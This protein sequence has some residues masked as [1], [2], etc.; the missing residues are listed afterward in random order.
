MPVLLTTENALLEKIGGHISLYVD[1]AKVKFSAN[2]NALNES[3][4]KVSISFFS[5]AD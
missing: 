2:K 4:L 3:K 5:L 1:G